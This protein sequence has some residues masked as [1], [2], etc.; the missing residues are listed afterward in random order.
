MMIIRPDLGDDQQ[1]EIFNKII[2]KIEGLEGKVSASKIWVKEHNFYYPLKSRGAEKKKYAKG[3][4][5]L[6][7]FLLDTDKMDELKEA[8]RLEERILRN[9]IISKEDQAAAL[10]RERS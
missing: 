1:Q 9:I 2:K 3:C 10:E 4:Y 6:V 7:N 8:M 5:W